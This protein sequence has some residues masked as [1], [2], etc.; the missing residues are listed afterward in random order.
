MKLKLIEIKENSLWVCRSYIKSH[1]ISLESLSILRACESLGTQWH[2]LC[3]NFFDF[4]ARTINGY[5]Q[6]DIQIF[7]SQSWV[8]L[9]PL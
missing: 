3:Y 6:I 8:R 4:L 9:K 1:F 7:S 5:L 2:H